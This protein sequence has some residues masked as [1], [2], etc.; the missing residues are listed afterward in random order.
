MSI[1]DVVD[2]ITRY[3]ASLLEG[4][5]TEEDLERELAET[6][7]AAEFGLT[8]IAPLP[9]SILRLSK[10]L[11]DPNFETRDAVGALES[12]PAL[13]VDVLRL[14]NSAA[15]VGSALCKSTQEAFNRLGAARI[16]DLVVSSHIEG[17]GASTSGY[18]RIVFN[19]SVR[20]AQIARALPSSATCT[21]ERLY[22][23]GLVH[24]IGMTLLDQTGEFTYYIDH[25]KD[26]VA[27]CSAERNVL[28]FDHSTLGAVA[29]A[30]WGL[31]EP[32]SEVLIAHHKPEQVL[33]RPGSVG[34]MLACLMI[35][36]DL[37]RCA[38][39]S[40]RVSEQDMERVASSLGCQRLQLSAA[41]LRSLWE[42][43][44]VGKLHKDTCA[45]SAA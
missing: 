40:D 29:T 7:A 14:A 22:L 11:A 9:E 2:R 26:D 10:V 34:R 38:G 15:F 8:G 37:E 28:G 23:A 30:F 35:A 16:K 36:E 17:L 1:R 25:Y 21:P 4:P 43:R 12:D 6:S 41:T 13:A 39:E 3:R 32:I 45:M 44:V 42:E 18:S 31:P 27:Q 24:D 33:S 19:H 5:P 20:V